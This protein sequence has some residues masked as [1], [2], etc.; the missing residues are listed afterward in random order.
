MC[1]E[2]VLGNYNVSNARYVNFTGEFTYTNMK[3]PLNQEMY[4]CLNKNGPHRP[5][6][7]CTIRRC[8]LAGVGVASLEEVS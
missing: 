1:I 4:G 3:D 8:G 5:I 2:T 6:G 7:N